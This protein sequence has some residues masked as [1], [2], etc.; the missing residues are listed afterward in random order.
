VPRINEEDAMANPSYSDLR[1]QLV[2]AAGLLFEAGVMSPSGHGN[3]SVRLPEPERL[4]LTATGTIRNLGP[5][6]LAVLT[7]DGEALEG[8]I[9]PVAHEIVGMH[10]CVYRARDEVG[11]VIHTH[12]PRATSFALAHQPL[13]VA[14]EALLRFGVTADIPVAKWA[15]R[16]SPE[17][18]AAIVAQLRA[19]PTVPALLLGNHGLLAFARDPL[20]AA[21]LIIVLEEA[22]QL[23]LDADTLG[24]AK[25]FPAGALERERDHMRRFAAAT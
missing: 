23:L 3:L 22:A 17:A 4:L 20:A 21:Q 9:E 7:F 24:G 12:S 18:V 16:G 8:E 11:A 1:D 10:T 6:Q 5:E 13:P 2:R 14:Y 15:P 19:H 25:P